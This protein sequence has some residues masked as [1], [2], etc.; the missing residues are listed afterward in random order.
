[1]N[2]VS[3]NTF[4]RN[5]I[6]QYCTGRKC[7]SYSAA[8]VNTQLHENWAALQQVK[9]YV[10]VCSFLCRSSTSAR[11]AWAALMAVWLFILPPAAR[12]N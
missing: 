7:V 2:I 3:D 1:L 6:N 8:Q 5:K 9:P 4:H 12:N 10:K 11:G